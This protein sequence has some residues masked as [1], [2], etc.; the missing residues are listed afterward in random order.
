MQALWGGLDAFDKAADEV[1]S[2]GKIDLA[3]IDAAG[4]RIPRLPGACLSTRR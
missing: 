4:G 3:A 2:M 1:M